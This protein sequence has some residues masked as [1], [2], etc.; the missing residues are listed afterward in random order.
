MESPTDPPELPSE[1][2]DSHSERTDRP[3]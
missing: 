3:E 2:R 1:Q